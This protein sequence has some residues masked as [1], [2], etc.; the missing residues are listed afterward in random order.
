M[1]G[2]E[3][4]VNMMIRIEKWLRF[5]M[6]GIFRMGSIRGRGVLIKG[7]KLPIE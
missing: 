4:I 5:I 7:V 1:M 6:K 3:F 2:M